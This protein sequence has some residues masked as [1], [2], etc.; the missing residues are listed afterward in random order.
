MQGRIAVAVAEDGHDFAGLSAA[1][2][3]QIIALVVA[4]AVGDLA[5]FRRQHGQSRAALEVAF[6]LADANR[7]QAR[8]A[9]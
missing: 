6:H 1:E 4:Q 9:L 7:Q 5:A 2:L 3:A 8:A